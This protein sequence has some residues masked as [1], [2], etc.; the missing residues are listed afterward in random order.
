MNLRSIIAG[1]LGV[2]VVFFGISIVFGSWYTI[3]QRERGVILRNGKLIGTAAPGLGFKLPIVDDVVK[4]SLE[5]QRVHFDKVNAYSR[6]QQPADFLISVNFRTTE[7]KVD[8]IYSQFGSIKN[9]ADRILMPKVLAESKIVFGRYNAVT[10][11]QERGRLNAEIMEAIVKAAAGPVVIESVQIENLDFSDAYEKSIEQRMLAEVEVQRIRQNAER[12]KV[13]A[14]IKVIQA[15]AT[16]EAVRK[17]AEAEADA[18]RLRGNAEAE[19][20]R[21]RATALGQNPNLVSLVQAE[22]WNGQ[23]PQTMVP[24]GSLPMIGLQK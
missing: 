4:I 24:G 19:A 13:Q 18:I 8:E 6:D 16:A 11:I 2:A 21:A 15:A 5:T 3:D 14:D 1:V 9:Y 12:E 10:A 7:D 23:L 22:K 17:Q 20:I